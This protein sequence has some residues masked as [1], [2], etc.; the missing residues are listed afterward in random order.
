MATTSPIT[1]ATRLTELA[2]EFVQLRTQG[3]TA[4]ARSKG[5]WMIITA[6]GHGNKLAWMGTPITAFCNAMPALRAMAAQ[7]Q[8]Q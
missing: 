3:I 8:P 1:P 6:T 2:A 7:A 5:R 4:R